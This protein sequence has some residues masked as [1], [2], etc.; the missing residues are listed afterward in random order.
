MRLLVDT[1]IKCGVED[2]E[3]LVSHC[4]GFFG[5]YLASFSILLF[6]I[7]ACLCYTIILGN[8]AQDVMEYLFDLGLG[9]TENRQLFIVFIHLFVIL[10]FHFI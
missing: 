3:R 9:T 8:C 6:D 4:F 1:G 2:Y 7:G 5:Y 10:P